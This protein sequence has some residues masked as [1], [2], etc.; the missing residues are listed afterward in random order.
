MLD[1]LRQAAEQHKKIV[2][3]IAGADKHFS[4]RIAEYAKQYHLERN[5][6]NVPPPK[7]WV[8]FLAAGKPVICNKIATHEWLV[9]HGKNGFILN[10]DPKE[11][12]EAILRLKN[13]ETLYRSMAENAFQTAEQYDM[14]HVYGNMVKLIKNSLNE[15]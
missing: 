11:V 8:K 3:V 4:E 9:N 13:D 6:L 5:I 1:S 14:D 12:S 10:S 2:L 7:K 15:A